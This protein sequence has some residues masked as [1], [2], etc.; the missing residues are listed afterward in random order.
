[1]IQEWKAK[2]IRVYE[3]YVSIT[4]ATSFSP[5]NDT[6]VERKATG[7]YFTDTYGTIDFT[8]D[9]RFVRDSVKRWES[10]IEGNWWP[11]IGMKEYKACYLGAEEPRGLGAIDL[12]P[13]DHYLGSW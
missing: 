4:E 13:S 2:I 1:L 7:Q 10:C 3:R 5:S 9:H 6:F 11:T 8:R 12:D